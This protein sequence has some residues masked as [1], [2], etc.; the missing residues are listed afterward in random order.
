MH[1]SLLAIMMR[2]HVSTKLR[3]CAIYRKTESSSLE[4]RMSEL[5]IPASRNLLFQFNGSVIPWPLCSPL[6]VLL[7]FIDVTTRDR[8]Y[9]P[10]ISDF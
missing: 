10:H 7:R 4:A 8:A 3:T 6:R 5:R 9:F 2:A 1:S